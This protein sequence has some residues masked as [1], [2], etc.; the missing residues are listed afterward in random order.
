VNS[1]FLFCVLP[2]AFSIQIPASVVSRYQLLAQKRGRSIRLL[3]FSGRAST[4]SEWTFSAEG[5]FRG[6]VNG[7]AF[8]L[9]SG[10]AWV[11][12]LNGGV[13]DKASRAVKNQALPARGFLKLR[14]GAILEGHILGGSEG[15]L[16]FKIDH[17]NK[18]E[19]PIEFVQGFRREVMASSAKTSST[20]GE[21]EKGRKKETKVRDANFSRALKSPPLESDL[22]FYSKGRDKRGRPLIRRIPCKV[23]GGTYREETKKAELLLQVGG[24]NRTLPL[25]KIYGVVFAEGSGIEAVAPKGTSV[26]RAKLRNGTILFGRLL[27]AGSSVPWT[28]QTLEGF[29]LRLSMETLQEVEFG[30]TKVHFVSMIPGV[31]VVQTP[32]LDRKWPTLKDHSPAGKSLK[33]RGKEFRHGFWVVP[34]LRIEIPWGKKSGRFLGQAGLVSRGNGLVTL[35]ILAD[36]KPLIENLELKGGDEPKVFQYKLKGIEKLVLELKGSFML[37]SGAA[38]ILGDLRILEQ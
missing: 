18:I 11:M 10:L 35:R 8:Q 5:G 23:L 30:S 9:A 3:S 34:N 12:A 21:G 20:F 22:C 29:K 31:Q 1:A 17:G 33:L 26:D 4:L 25:S 27:S 24:R 2:L 13:E 6:K 16:L 28:F 37:D 38:V 36:G 7:K 14:S 15:T 32:T 19:V